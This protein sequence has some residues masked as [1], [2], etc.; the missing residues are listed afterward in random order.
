MS[1]LLAIRDIVVVVFPTQNPK[2]REQEGYR[3]AIVAG[4]P[5]NLGVPRFNVGIVV[6]LTTDRHQS[7]AISSPE[8]YPRFEAGTGNLPKNSIVLLDQIRTIDLNRIIR[9]LGTLT[10]VQYLPI[11]NALRTILDLNS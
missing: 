5:E 7:W 10:T 6:P 1:E 3:P 4:L 9:Y 2:G 8:L 11:Q